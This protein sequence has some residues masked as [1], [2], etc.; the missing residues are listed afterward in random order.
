[1]ENTGQVLHQLPEIHPL[2]GGE[3]EQNLTA[4]KG[5]FRADKLH[6]QTVFGNFLHTHI[7]GA[8]FPCPVVGHDFQILLGG[9]AENFPQRGHDFLPADGVVGPGAGTEFR[10]P[11]GIHDDGIPGD[12]LHPIGIKIVNLL[13]RAELNVHDLQGFGQVVC[14][15]FHENA[16][17]MITD[18]IR[19]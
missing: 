16:P 9:K 14:N 18:R 11:G 6:I 1:M 2:V 10:P 15:F 8:F 5:V 4:V 13:P 3:V 19:E 12:K 7:V 17:F